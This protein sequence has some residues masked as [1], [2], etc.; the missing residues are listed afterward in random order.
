MLNIKY[1]IKL[2]IICE[3][4]ILL[5]SLQWIQ[6]HLLFVTTLKINLATN[7]PTSGFDGLSWNLIVSQIIKK[8]LSFIET[9]SYYHVTKALF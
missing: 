3:C 5:L 9:E 8:S 7:Q 6:L 1:Y 2:T 4:T